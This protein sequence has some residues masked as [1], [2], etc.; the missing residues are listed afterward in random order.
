MIDFE[1]TQIAKPFEKIHV[2]EQFENAE[3]QKSVA[4][5][6][7]WT[8]LSTEVL[9]FGGLF[10]VYIIYRVIYPEAFAEASRHTKLIIGAINTA[11]LLSSSLTMALAVHYSKLGKKHPLVVYLVCTA[12][13][14]V[15]FMGLKGIEYYQ[16][17]QDHA[18][19]YFNYAL[20][21]ADPARGELFFIIYFVMTL[22]H[23]LHLTIG[24]GL[25]S[26]IAFQALKNKYSPSYHTPVELTGLYWHF[27]DIIWVFLFPLLYLIDRSPS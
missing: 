17:Y 23:A 18:V 9:F 22:I 14:G 11:V 12:L 16:D 4:Q 27:V 5:I 6:G 20:K 10:A 21:I 13:F 3:Q 8:F 24:I 7:M 19:P 25:I 1:S 2:A 26:F 15:V